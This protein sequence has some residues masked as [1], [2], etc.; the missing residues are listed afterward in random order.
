[1]TT[2]RGAALA[3]AED[4]AP[5]KTLEAIDPLLGTAIGPRFG[6]PDAANVIDACALSQAS[7]VA[8]RDLTRNDRRA[9]LLKRIAAGIEGIGDP[10]IER[11]VAESGLPRARLHGERGR[12][13]SRLRLFAKV[14]RDGAWL[15]VTIDPTQ[16]ERQ[17]MVHPDLRRVGG[18]C[19]Q[20]PTA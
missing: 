7:A 2:I 14:V 17:P 4:R 1:M 5:T 8:F 16:P 9:D 13:V 11:A 18:E 15:D 19:E 10:P 3:G 12:T 6:E 20:T